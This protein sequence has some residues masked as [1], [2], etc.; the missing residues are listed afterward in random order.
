MDNATVVSGLL[1]KRAEIQKAI[2]DVEREARKHVRAHRVAL[3]K[4]DATIEL[5]ESGVVAA[6]R[7]QSMGERSV[8]FVT[9][10][11]TRRC[12]TALRDAHGQ[13]VTADLIAVSA[14]REKHLDLGDGELR[15]DITRRI[16]WTLN[17]L[18]TRKAVMKDGWGA[19][20]RWTLPAK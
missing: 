4:I 15:Q 7:K 14:M 13:P 3:A 6:K 8:H 1:A 12:Q 17:R 11:L 20:A 2:N 10:E 16:L 5:F 19:D 18:A 9:G